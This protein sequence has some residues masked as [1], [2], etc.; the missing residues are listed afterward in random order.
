MNHGGVRA[1]QEHSRFWCEHNPGFIEGH[2][3][4]TR[5]VATSRAASPLECPGRFS[6]YR[7]M[8]LWILLNRVPHLSHILHL[9]AMAI[10]A[11]TVDTRLFFLSTLE[12]TSNTTIGLTLDFVLVARTL[13]SIQTALRPAEALLFPPVRVPCLADYRYLANTVHEIF[14][15]A[16]RGFAA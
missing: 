16:C 11:G 15:Q 6:E 7:G 14:D 3:K 2:T 1:F 10:N 8:E 12:K 5:N 4:V 9:A 13:P